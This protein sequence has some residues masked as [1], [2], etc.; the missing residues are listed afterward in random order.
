LGF[1]AI[2]SLGW[3][4]DRTRRTDP[5]RVARHW[6]V[7]AVATIWTLATATRIEDATLLHLPPAV[8]HRP[9]RRPA[10]RPPGV[11]RTV[12]LLAQGLVALR[13]QLILGRRWTCIW[14]RPEP[15]PEPPPGIQVDYHDST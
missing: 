7:L 2:K 9:P 15:W 5:S 10:W 13:C 1:K 3:H 14:L 4:W 11:T 8:L 12:S 6:L